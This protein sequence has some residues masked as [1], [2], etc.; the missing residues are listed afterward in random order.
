MAELE[1]FLTLQEATDKYKISTEVLTQLVE[2]G[3][4]RAV[5]LDGTI[6]V[7]EGDVREQARQRQ[8]IEQLRQKYQHLEDKSIGAYEAETKYGLRTASLYR[9][10][11]AGLV[12]V[13][14]RGWGRK[15]NERDIA[16]ISELAMLGELRK[17]RALSLI[18]NS[19][20]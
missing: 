1:S 10:A 12:R 4:I 18:L 16:I 13:M 8:M 2:S 6:A 15:F 14:E 20:K 19:G 17:G 7:A 11:D 3:K 9:W 5:R